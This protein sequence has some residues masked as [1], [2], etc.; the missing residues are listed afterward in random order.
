VFSIVFLVAYIA[1]PYLSIHSFMDALAL[2]LTIAALAGATLVL[3][4]PSVPVR[5]VSR[6]AVQLWK[7][8][9]LQTFSLGDAFT[10]GREPTEV[11]DKFVG[12]HPVGHRSTS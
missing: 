12:Q 9:G 8:V 5:R 11:G 10:H 6:A 1:Y 3:I 7:F 4:V 2:L